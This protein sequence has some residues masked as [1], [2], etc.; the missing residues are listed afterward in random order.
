VSHGFDRR[1]YL[2]LRV[3]AYVFDHRYEPRMQSDITARVQ[4]QL[5]RNGWLQVWPGA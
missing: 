5:R 2:R 1:P 4:E 3:K